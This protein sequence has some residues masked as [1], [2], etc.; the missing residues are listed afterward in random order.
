MNIKIN[1]LFFYILKSFQF[2][3][4]DLRFSLECYSSK[5]HKIYTILIRLTCYVQGF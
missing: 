2:R 5:T 1:E 4:E 3:V